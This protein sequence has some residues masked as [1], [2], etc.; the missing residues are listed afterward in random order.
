MAQTQVAR[1]TDIE[2]CV[3]VGDGGP[4]CSSLDATMHLEIYILTGAAG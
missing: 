1:S 2:L 3:G 4:A